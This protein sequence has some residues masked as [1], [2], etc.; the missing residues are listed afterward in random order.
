MSII[1][2]MEA[3]SGT[4]TQSRTSLSSCISCAPIWYAC[5]V[6]HCV[7]AMSQT[8]HLCW[9]SKKYGKGEWTNKFTVSQTAGG[10]LICGGQGM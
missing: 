4:S 1:R 5:C 3:V 7:F 8:F 2:K 6:L 10:R 9:M